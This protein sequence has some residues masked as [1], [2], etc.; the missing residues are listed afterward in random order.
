MANV[1]AIYQNGVFKP[2]SVLELPEN[3]RVRLSIQIADQS[4]IEAWLTEAKNLQ[5][6][7]VAHFGMLPDSTTD[8]AADRMRND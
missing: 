8:I 4:G 5:A 1:E 3:Q 2:L 7:I 6:S